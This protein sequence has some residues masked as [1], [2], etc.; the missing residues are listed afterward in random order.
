MIYIAAYGNGSPCRL[1][2]I[3]AHEQIP[4]H[5][6]AK[7]LQ[8]LAKKRLVKSSKGIKGGFALNQPPEKTT[9]YLIVDSIDDLSLSLG[10]CILGRGTCS[11]LQHCPLHESWKQLKEMQTRLLQHTTLADMAASESRIAE[12]AQTTAENP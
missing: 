10:D 7:I 4:Q 9:L 11:D 2:A 5:F 12:T 8:R 1:E 6:L 3:A